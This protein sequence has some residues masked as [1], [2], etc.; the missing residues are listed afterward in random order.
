[1][2]PLLD[3]ILK[4]ET[5]YGQLAQAHA[6]IKKRGGKGEPPLPAI[7]L[8]TAELDAWRRYFVEHLGFEPLAMKRLV[9]GLSKEMTV[10]DDWPE[11]FDG[12]YRARGA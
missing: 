12:S 8:N 10:P 4:K 2:K 9:W 5:A 7:K 11:N 6:S 1:M 3:E